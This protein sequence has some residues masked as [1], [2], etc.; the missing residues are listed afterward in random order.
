[1]SQEF[2][3]YYLE[4]DL[5]RAFSSS[6]VEPKEL[7]QRTLHHY[8]DA[9][10][11]GESR[12][13]FLQAQA[14]ISQLPSC[15]E[16]FKKRVA[17]DYLA[18]TLLQHS[19]EEWNEIISY[20]PDD[21]LSQSILSLYQY[22]K[23]DTPMEDICIPPQL[24]QW[25]QLQYTMIK[26]AKLA[27]ISTSSRPLLPLPY[28]APD[29]S[30]EEKEGTPVY[31]LDHYRPHLPKG[32]FVL[33]HPAQRF[34]YLQH[35]SE[36]DCFVFG[37]FP[38]LYSEPLYP[39]V[40]SSFSTL[41]EVAPWIVENFSKRLEVYHLCHEL[42][43]TLS[44][45]R[46]GGS[47]IFSSVFNHTF[48][49]RYDKHK[50]VVTSFVFKNNLIKLENKALSSILIKSTP[51]PKKKKLQLAHVV[52]RL[53]D[54]SHYAPSKILETMLLHHDEELFDLSVISLEQ[55]ALFSSQYP[56][57]KFQ[58]RQS[59]EAGRN[60]IV[61]F[62]KKGIRVFIPTLSR[63]YE[64]AV[65]KIIEHIEEFPLD[66]LCFHECPPMTSILVNQIAGPLK[67]FIDHGTR[68][69]SHGGFD[70]MIISH[71]KESG[72][73]PSFYEKKGA[74]VFDLPMVADVSLLPSTWTKKDLGVSEDTVVLATV[75]NYLEERIS[76]EMLDVIE[77]LLKANPNTLYV[78]IGPVRTLNLAKELKKRGVL[79]QVCFLGSVQDPIRY[80]YA[81]DIY[82]TEFPHGGSIAV[83]EAMGARCAIVALYSEKGDPQARYAGKYV[84]LDESCYTSLEYFE[85]AS[86]LIKDKQERLR[87]SEYCYGRFKYFV[88]PKPY[89]KKLEERIL[90]H[91]KLSSE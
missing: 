30:F 20:V 89:V 31:F 80:L 82:L 4:G 32:L 27:G 78:L 77:K 63:D 56:M 76:N 18:L 52:P 8:Q 38:P 49:K 55:Y 47:S 43:E 62:E 5:Y 60:R 19:A 51:K 42:R 15:L 88:Q 74:Q 57:P 26:N 7:W 50:D 45:E 39:V 48:E 79:K 86:L 59:R 71:L 54:A 40:D 29:F 1:M 53:G 46:I 33:Y 87:F 44:V 21:A 67:V 2:I 34:H 69:P 37:E 41:H 85:K 25:W 28:H 81:V 70:L 36:F 91:G 61:E 22:E 23:F 84:G 9:L 72:V 68:Y 90:S 24:K 3:Q 73:D 75:S 66:I 11:W 17:L 14:L 83:Q 10:C 65:D 58:A 12:E 13:I 6:K 35:T 16:R 64:E